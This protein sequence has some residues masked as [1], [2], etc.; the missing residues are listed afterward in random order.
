MRKWFLFLS[1]GSVLL[2]GVVLLLEGQRG[3]TPSAFDAGDG[4]P[5]VALDG[6]PVGVA[7]EKEG[8]TGLEPRALPRSVPKPSGEGDLVDYV[9]WMR[10]LG[11]DELLRLSNAEFD[12]EESELIQTLLDL[13]GEWVVKALG[14]LAIA[15]SDPLL[16]AILVVGLTRTISDERLDD[17]HVIPILDQLLGGLRQASSDPHGVAENL[18]V[19]AYCA[20]HRG[21]GDYAALMSAHLAR[22]DNRMLLIN[23]YMFFGHTSEGR[24]TLIQMLT[25]HPSDAGRF[26]ALEGLRGAALN[27]H[28]PPAELTNLGWS[29]LES[30][31]NE[32]NRL[33]LYEMMV[34]GGGEEALADLEQA[35]RSGRL[36]EIEK[37]ASLL[38]LKMAPARAQALF[39]DTLRDRELD[40]EERQAIY[41]AMGAMEGAQGAEF[42]LE[43]VR[44]EALAPEERLAGLRGLWNRA[45]DESLAGELGA[46]FENSSDAAMRVEALRML[47]HGETAGAGL[48]LRTVAT[49]D[50]RPEVRAQAI[51]LAAMQPG[52][53]TRGWLEERMLED[54]SYDVKAAALGALVYHAHYAGDGDEVLDYLSRARMLTDDEHA[55]AMIAQGEQMVKDYDPRN[56]DIRLAQEAEVWAKAA[57]LTDGPASRM[58]QRQSRVLSELVAAMRGAQVGRSAKR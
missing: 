27:G 55:L 7:A 8:R 41:N 25:G 22:S 2:I 16:K 57:Q 47:A 44:N 46:I 45:I 4:G 23:G 26:G 58:F 49:L 38:A 5:S 31:T 19:F 42:L 50:D 14:E 24:D 56:V 34:A 6:F 51:E 13:K 37:T 35:W 32:R 21:N 1:A 54:D 30:E 28:I 11:H 33:L 17:E 12:F 52:E 10:S 18:A 9:A 20:C 40:A 15:E 43:Q 36:D 29:A 39:E 53:D 48:D 3:P